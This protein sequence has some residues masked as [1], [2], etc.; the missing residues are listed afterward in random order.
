MVRVAASVRVVASAWLSAATATTARLP[1]LLGAAA[2]PARPLPLAPLN[3]PCLQP[4]LRPWLLE[5][6]PASAGRNVQGKEGSRRLQL[7]SG[8]MGPQ[9]EWEHRSARSM[10]PHP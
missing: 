10:C 1:D 7:D 6:P 2:S 3:A 4:S 8:A 5:L 9:P